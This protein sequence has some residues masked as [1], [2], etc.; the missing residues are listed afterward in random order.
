MNFL[1]GQV[2]AGPCL[3]TKGVSLQL[4][5]AP[6]WLSGQEGR[7]LTLG[8]RPESVKICSSAEEPTSPSRLSMEVIAV[9]ALGGFCLVKLQRG[10]WHLTAWRQGACSLQER[11][12][13]AVELDASRFH[14]F[15]PRTERALAAPA[16]AE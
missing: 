12:T 5:R 6:H 1:R 4:G 8:V 2:E 14:W 7:S 11:E 13:A 9:E 3:T 10:E 15:D 16:D